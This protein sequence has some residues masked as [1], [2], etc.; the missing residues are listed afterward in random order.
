MHTMLWQSSC[1][2]QKCT[3]W[4][5]NCILRGVQGI[6]IKGT[7]WDKSRIPEVLA[8]ILNYCGTCQ[9]FNSNDN[10]TAL[11]NSVLK[12][13]MDPPGGLKDRYFEPLTWFDY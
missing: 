2:H 6:G 11:L 1:F 9:N 4:V 12:T 5:E 10:K 7:R 8:V 13:A 3:I